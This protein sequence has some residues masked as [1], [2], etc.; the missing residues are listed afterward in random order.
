[1]PAKKKPTTLRPDQS[2]GKKVK[3]K[4]VVETKGIIE[5]AAKVGLATF[6]KENPE[7]SQYL[8]LQL[9]MGT[10]PPTARQEFH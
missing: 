7:F 1:M 5:N 3:P 9:G 8:N 2:D 10:V 6:E 4:K